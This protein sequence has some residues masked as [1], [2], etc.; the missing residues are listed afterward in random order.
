MGYNSP[1]KLAKLGSNGT[2][3]GDFEVT[4]NQ[5]K[6]GDTRPGAEGHKGATQSSWRR[7]GRCRKESS[8]LSLETGWG[9]LI[10]LTRGAWQT[11]RGLLT[12]VITVNR[13][14]ADWADGEHGVLMFPGAART[15][16]GQTN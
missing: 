7:D 6:L 9:P 10:V 1:K 15:R 16:M 2:V 8:Q 11:G 3:P 12:G 5:P 13:L 14:A 4:S